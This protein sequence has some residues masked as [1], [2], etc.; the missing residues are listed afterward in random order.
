[1]PLIACMEKK[2]QASLTRVWGNTSNPPPLPKMAQSSSGNR[3]AKTAKIS[4]L[5]AGMN[6]T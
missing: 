2:I 1:M 5:N 3:R 6:W 4:L